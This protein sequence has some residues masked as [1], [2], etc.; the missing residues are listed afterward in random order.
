V[1]I[2]Q[3]ATPLFEE[4]TRQAEKDIDDTIDLD[5]YSE[6]YNAFIYLQTFA[7]ELLKDPVNTP[8]VCLFNPPDGNWNN[9]YVIRSEVGWY[10]VYW[11]GE[12]GGATPGE[13]SGTFL[14]VLLFDENGQPV[15]SV[16]DRIRRMLR[17]K[18]PLPDAASSQLSKIFDSANPVAELFR[19]IGKPK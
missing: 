16:L 5:L 18:S 7:A 13:Q 12:S 17:E 9:L 10:L 3:K 4:L 11:Y 19:A 6:R 2:Q 15:R 8:G 1:A 14:A